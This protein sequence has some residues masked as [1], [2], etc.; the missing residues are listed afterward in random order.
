[1]LVDLPV[2]L[3]CQQTNI[4]IR[5]QGIMGEDEQHLEGVGDK[6]R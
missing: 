3:V 5:T 2:Y 6:D 1:M 4:G